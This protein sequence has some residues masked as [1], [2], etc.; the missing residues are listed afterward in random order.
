MFHILEVVKMDERAGALEINK[1]TGSSPR[2]RDL[3]LVAREG[4]KVPAYAGMTP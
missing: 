2:R 4:K 3:C 1:H